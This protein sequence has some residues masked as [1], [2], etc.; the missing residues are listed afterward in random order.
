MREMSRRSF[1]TGSVLMGAGIGATVLGGCSS[2]QAKPSD[3]Q[4]PVEPAAEQPGGEGES[5]ETDLR[6][7][8]ETDVLVCG[9]GGAGAACAIEAANGG[10]EVLL[11]E[12]GKLP[13]GSMCRSGG[14]MAGAGTTMQ[15]EAGI[16]DSADEFYDWIML[17]TDGLC[18]ADI[19]R[20]YADNSAANLD[21]M[22]ELSVKETGEHLFLAELTDDKARIGI[23]RRGVPY[24]SFGLTV[25]EVTPRSHWAA[26][27]EGSTAS[28]AGPELFYPLLLTVQGSDKITVQ[29][30]TALLSLITDADGAVLGATVSDNGT[31]KSVRARKGVMLATGGF[32]N[33][34]EFR[35]NFCFDTMGRIS[36]MNPL[37]TGDGVKA[38]MAV[39]AGLA[40][41]CQSYIMPDET[42]YTATFNEE[43]EDVFPMWLQ[44]P[45]DPNK[46]VAEAPIIAETHGGVVIDTDARVLD[47]WGNPIPNLYAAGCDVGS[48]IFGK[49]GNYPGCG[50]YVG[51]AIC[52]G[53]IAGENLAGAPEPEGDK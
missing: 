1:L 3:A 10:A 14:G 31:E 29:Y 15:K 46:L 40:N 42:S 32:P 33:S 24:A 21:W 12:K 44:A 38:A 47:V 18:P 48:N 22:D 8:V 19:A 20:V 49:S 17:A 11:I 39:G 5:A 35:K 13:G 4:A 27:K 30:E 34:E 43:W 2:Q 7:D 36:Y 23:N 37:C 26:M 52:F 41:T 16:A 50:S 25:E 51:F 45:D 53:R 6:W 28:N 9:F